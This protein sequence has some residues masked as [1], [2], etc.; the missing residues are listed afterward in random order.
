[1]AVSFFFNGRK[2]IEP[3]AYSRIVSGIKN[4][5]RD[6]NYG[7]ILIIDNGLGIGFGA[8]PGVNGEL[9]GGKNSIQ[10]FDEMKAFKSA[11]RGGP[12]WAAAP[13]LFKPKGRSIPGIS[14]LFYARAATTTAAVMTFSPVG[15]SS[16]GG[17][18]TIKPRNE[19]TG[20]NGVKT[21]TEL[22]SGY[23]FKMRAGKTSGYFVLDFYVGTFTGLDSLDSNP[24]SGN[25][26]EL[27]IAKL[28]V[29]TP[30]FNNLSQIESW[31]NNNS[32][33]LAYFEIGSFIKTGDGS[34]DVADAVT[35]ADFTLA[36][37]GTE[38]FSQDDLTTLFESITDL[39]YAFILSDVFG[40]DA[41][42]DSKTATILSHI[43]ND[44]KYDKYLIIGGGADSTEFNNGTDG[45]VEIAQDYNTSR[46]VVVHGNFYKRF[47][48]T[49]INNISSTI[50]KEYSSFI[51]AANVLGR[52]LGN[53][54]Q[55]PGTFKSVDID[56]EVHEL[57]KGERET[58]LEN[59]VLV[60]KF[61][62]EVNDYIILQSIN[63]LQNN[64][65][66]VNE[67]DGQSYEISVERIKSQLNKE[68]VIRA[69]IELL[70][71]SEGVNRNTLSETDLKVW[72]QNF[73]RRKTV[74]TSNDN[75]ILGYE[76]V[77]VVTEQDSYKVTYG[78]YPNFPI[79]KLFM[80]GVMLDSTI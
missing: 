59:G 6:F 36:T 27:E 25:P 14:K 18:V 58:A 65:F 76:N 42:Q 57:N 24:W 4:P 78:F 26:K 40:T 38:T 15:G 34:V 23:A 22:T 54:P 20:A 69:R 51:K 1:M 80:T 55:V 31:M 29:S 35:Y 32:T 19:G 63:S 52:I 67:S 2:V 30:E 43:Q 39:D 21:G 46:V 5:I 45:S 12:F 66:L 48:V 28:L 73:L 77:T 9:D 7:N 74:T 50:L 49:D 62:S 64:S 56:G 53:E 75:L 72:T 11:V 41:Y 79:N 13:F 10:T 44:A 17:I 37:G 61:D 3:G 47:R 70:D 68:L 71:Q 60:T 8:G 16:N 33:F